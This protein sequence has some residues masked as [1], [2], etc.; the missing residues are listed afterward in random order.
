MSY[1]LTQDETVSDG[2]K[3]IVIEQAEQAIE[4]LESQRGSQDDSIHAARVCF[5]KI[6]AVLRLVRTEF[7]AER[8]RQ[9]NICYRDAGRRLSAIR[10]T[11]ALRETFEKLTVR[12]AD[13]L[14]PNAFAELHRS[15][16]QSSMA[17]RLEKKK[18]MLAVAKITATARRRVEHWPLQQDGFTALRQGVKGVYKRGRQSSANA[19]A[20]PSV[21]H[22][23]E[24]RKDVKYLRYQIRLLKPIWS[25]VLGKLGD[26][27]ETLGEYLSED[28]DL[29]L[30]RQCVLEPAEPTDNRMDLEAL[31]AL[32]DRRRGEL[33]GDAKWLGERVYAERPRAF[34][35]RLQVYWQTW[36]SDAPIHA[37]SVS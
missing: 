20:Q 17:Q 31:I 2:I 30:L 6:R 13:Q 14:A 28:H 5:K 27:L 37:I 10:D 22:L 23:H 9:E 15:L 19:L 25:T 16:R 8:F 32:I 7:G 33:Q 3:R 1:R 18:A 12:F 24:W 11:A 26:E 35:G 34:V 21:E 36:R 29:A 4:G